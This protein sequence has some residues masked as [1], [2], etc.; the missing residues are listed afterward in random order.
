MRRAL[1]LL[2]A[3]SLGAAPLTAQ[4]TTAP[5][6]SLTQQAKKADVIVRAT[7]GTPSTVKEGEVTWLVYPLTVT[8]TVAGDAASLP[9][10]EGQPALYLLSGMEG[11]PTLRP[12]QEAF[13]L[14]YSK[15]LDSP[16]VGFWQGVYPIENGKVTHPAPGTNPALGSG[17]AVGTQAAPTPSAVPTTTGPTTAAATP[18]INAANPTT[19]SSPSSASPTS[20]IPNSTPASSATST[21]T[22]AS[23]APAG[24]APTSPPPTGPASGAPSTANPPTPGDLDASLSDPA[25]FRDALRAARE[26]K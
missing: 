11:L 12:G 21:S 14:L 15:R 1:T 20:A 26:A 10:R 6:L 17:T 7:L 3:L 22:P 5:P 19:G 4:A 23:P 25:K 2:A 24:S 16:I 13:L 9:Q 8:E 18:G